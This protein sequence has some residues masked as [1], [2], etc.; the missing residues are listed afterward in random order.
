MGNLALLSSLDPGAWSSSLLLA[1]GGGVIG[2]T[3]RSPPLSTER[4]E[5]EAPVFRLQWGRP[6]CTDPLTGAV[7]LG[8]VSA[9]V[10]LG[11]CKPQSLRLGA[12]VG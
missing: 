7:S 11:H 1:D 3:E 6:D 12:R 9:S 4:R 10:T 8:D 2:L 5:A